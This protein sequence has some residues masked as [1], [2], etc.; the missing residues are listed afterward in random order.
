MNGYSTTGGSIYTEYYADGVNYSEPE[1]Y[2]I[3]L[4]RS[5]EPEPEVP[6]LG[7]NSVASPVP[8]AASWNEK[9]QA[10]LAM[11]NGYEKFKQLSSLAKDFTY[12][13]KIY[14]SMII[15]YWG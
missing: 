15:R 12:S 9:F 1:S 8:H 5:E 6:V 14:G 3:S 4:E 7:A 13:A 2:S 11:K 10:I